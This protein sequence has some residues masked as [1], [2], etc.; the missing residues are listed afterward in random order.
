[1]PWLLNIGGKIRGPFDAA[2]IR[3]LAEAGELRPSDLMWRSGMKSWVPAQEV[4]G[5]FVHSDG[6]SPLPPGGGAMSDQSDGEG[7]EPTTVAVGDAVAWPRTRC[8]ARFGVNSAMWLTLAY[9]ALELFQVSQLIVKSLQAEPGSLRRMFGLLLSN[10]VGVFYLVGDPLYMAL[11]IWSALQPI[12]YLVSGG[13][14]HKRS[15]SQVSAGVAP[16]ADSVIRF[17]GLACWPIYLNRF[18]GPVIVRVAYGREGLWNDMRTF[19]SGLALLTLGLVILVYPGPRI[20][21]RIWRAVWSFTIAAG[22]AV[23]RAL[24]DWVR[25]EWNRR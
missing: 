6:P 22:R 16:V 24:G 14:S 19:V 12:A 9:T 21:V 15:S 4:K 13:W 1:V 5:V 18:W 2:R 10:T 25:G 17:I 8:A 20:I 11:W 7:V 3:A 23:S